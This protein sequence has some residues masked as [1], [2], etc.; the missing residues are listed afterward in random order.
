M[1]DLA[2][3]VAFF[4]LALLSPSERAH[5]LWEQARR[6]I[7]ERPK[8]AERSLR[9]AG[10]LFNQERMFQQRLGVLEDLA[11]LLDSASRNDE[12]Q[13]VRNEIKREVEG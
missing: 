5:R 8:Q 4:K 12:A 13:A 1:I 3:S 7:P 11:N 10:E 2:E 6:E 9:A